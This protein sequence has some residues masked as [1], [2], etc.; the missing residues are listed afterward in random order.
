MNGLRITT[1]TQL[2]PQVYF[3]PEGITIDSDNV[4]LDGRAATIM[5]TDKTGQGPALLG[6]KILRAPLCIS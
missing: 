2:A 1:D 6:E 5:R 4:T 3:M